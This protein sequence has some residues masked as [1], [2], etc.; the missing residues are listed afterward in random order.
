M[1]KKRKESELHKIE[2][3]SK[4]TNKQ[5]VQSIEIDKQDI[6]TV[7]AKKIIRIRIKSL[8]TNINI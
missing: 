8:Q 5:T 4:Q 3:Q 6:F 2:K 1:Y 7:Q